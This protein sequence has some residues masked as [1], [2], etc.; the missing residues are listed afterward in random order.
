[1]KSISWI[2]AIVFIMVTAAIFA[3]CS[4]STSDNS[5]LSTEIISG[6]VRD[7]GGNP[8]ASA[9]V[10]AR[11]RATARTFL[12]HTDSNGLYTITVT[13]GVYD[14]SVDAIIKELE[15][16][17]ITGV[18]QYVAQYTGP[19]TAPFK[20]DFVM[21]EFISGTNS[22]DISGTLL[23]TDGSPLS[24]ARVELI[25]PRAN[26][27][28]DPSLPMASFTTG[29]N[30]EFDIELPDTEGDLPI[31]M[32]IYDSTDNLIEFIVMDKLKDRP[33]NCAFTVGGPDKNVYRAEEY[34]PD[35]EEVLPGD[36]VNRWARGVRMYVFNFAQGWIISPLLSTQFNGGE[37]TYRSQ[38]LDRGVRELNYSEWGRATAD[39]SRDIYLYWAY[40]NNTDWVR[41]D[42]PFDWFEAKACSNP[43][44][45]LYNSNDHVDRFW[46]RTWD[47]G[48]NRW[49]NWMIRGT[50]D[51]SNWDATTL[52]KG[53]GGGGG[54]F[55]LDSG[56][57]TNDYLFSPVILVVFE[58]GVSYEEG[59]ARF[60]KYYSV[61]C[62]STDGGYACY[63]YV[64]WED[65]K[66]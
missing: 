46:I 65:L 62:R 38:T 54:D 63:P 25:S 8:I 30:G 33:I 14:I 60:K 37:R 57:K 6:Y 31:N 53:E 49:Y 23:K 52:L 26:S 45:D 21:E 4:G 3:G 35:P 29:D 22:E 18:T 24:G 50:N 44:Y 66:K 56:R 27:V 42:F 48:Y 32:Y 51:D 58:K 19:F 39:V 40:K 9:S 43:K 36:Q 11:N 15:N 28:I 5:G 20:K 12:S 59:E 1:M 55:I 7:T 47:S 10:V 2:P 34:S 16:G 61:S 41:I 64:V 13:P 17:E